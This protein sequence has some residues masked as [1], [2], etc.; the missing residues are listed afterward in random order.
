MNTCHEPSVDTTSVKS[1]STR[2]EFQND[3]RTRGLVAGDHQPQSTPEILT[4]A[5]VEAYNPNDA[6][7]EKLETL[8]HTHFTRLDD[9]F[10]DPDDEICSILGLD[11]QCLVSEVRGSKR[12][13]EMEVH[14]DVK[15]LEPLHNLP[16]FIEIEP[17]DFSDE[18]GTATVALDDRNPQL[19]ALMEVRAEYWA[20]H[21]T[22]E[23]ADGIISGK[24]AV[25]NLAADRDA[26]VSAHRNLRKNKPLPRAKS[27]AEARQQVRVCSRILAWLDD[28]DSTDAPQ[29]AALDTEHTNP[30]L[31]ADFESFAH[32]R[33]TRFATEAATRTNPT[34]VHAAEARDKSEDVFGDY[35]EMLI[36]KRSK[37]AEYARVAG[38]E[39]FAHHKAKLALWQ[40]GWTS[41][42]PCPAMPATYVGLPPQL[43]ADLKLT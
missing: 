3:Q 5:V 13:R 38:A 7:A 23:E 31:P 25:W 20:N 21:W 14:G 42:T 36:S 6:F 28:N 26:L 30:D 22:R 18:R 40:T 17:D 35:V 11:Q 9:H 33:S 37:E 8:V 19:L 10:D 16:G 29:V 34:D 41:A 43:K 27:A 39:E 24:Y 15:D 1:M 32:M 4:R 12:R 2:H